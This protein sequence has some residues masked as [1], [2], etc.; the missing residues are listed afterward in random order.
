M[1]IPA[2]TCDAALAKRNDIGPAAKA[3]VRVA[4][5]NVSAVLEMI[6]RC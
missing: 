2:Q 6:M 5:L 4:S 1:A 3:E